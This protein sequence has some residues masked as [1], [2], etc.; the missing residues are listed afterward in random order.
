MKTTKKHST[1]LHVR[2]SFQWIFEVSVVNR[3]NGVTSEKINSVFTD[4]EG[5][6]I[7]IVE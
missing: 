1:K 4:E 5:T 7:L 3:E 6:D 2:S